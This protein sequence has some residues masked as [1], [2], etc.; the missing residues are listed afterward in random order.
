MT[1]TA[2]HDPVTQLLAQ[3]LGASYEATAALPD[4][5]PL[6]GAGLGLDSRTAVTLLARIKSEIGV[7]VAAED[8]FLDALESVGAL[9]EFVLARLAT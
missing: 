2:G 6:L 5:T 3:L 7:D 4:A 9:R 1:A 8:L